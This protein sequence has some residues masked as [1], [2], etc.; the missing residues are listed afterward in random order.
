MTNGKAEMKGPIKGIVSLIIIIIA[1][2][3]LFWYFKGGDDPALARDIKVL[4]IDVE[5]GQKVETVLKAKESFPLKDSKTGHSLWAAY[6]C[7]N[8][9]ILFPATP[10]TMVSACPHCRDG[11]V[12]SVSIGSEEAKWDVKMPNP[13]PQI[14][15]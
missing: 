15:Q 6:A 10:K 13:L 5:T 14:P 3:F 1:F 9:H 7:Q 12:G 8:E 4:A 11:N 2:V